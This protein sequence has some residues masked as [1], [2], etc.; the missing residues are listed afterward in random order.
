MTSLP[1]NKRAFIAIEKLRD[2]CLNPFHPVGKDKA[3]IFR[4]ALGL[5][6]QDA[7]FL[8]KAIM[9]KLPESKATAGK[10]DQYGKRYTVDMKIRNLD[11]EAAIRTGWIVKTSE[12]F[13]RLTTCY[14]K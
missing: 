12:N 10:E 4:L 7:D 5:T 14:V 2:Y 8:M 6:D 3:I 11:K 9:K 13:P 1:N